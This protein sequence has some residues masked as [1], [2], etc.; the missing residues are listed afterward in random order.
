MIDPRGTLCYS[1][2]V[3]AKVGKIEKEL[4]APDQFVSFWGEVGKKAGAHKRELL[5]GLVVVILVAL[6]AWI[7]QVF[8]AGRAEKATQAFAKINRVISTPL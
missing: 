4:K 6:F 7:A 8:M 1:L 5:I 2:P 3:A